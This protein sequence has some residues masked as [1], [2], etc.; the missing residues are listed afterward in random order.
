MRGRLALGVLTGLALLLGFASLGLRSSYPPQSPP[1]QFL[2]TPTSP[3]PPTSTPTSPPT[4]TPIVP[5]ATVAATDAPTNTPV[6]PGP[7]PTGNRGGRPE[8][9]PPLPSTGIQTS[10][11]AQVRGAQG[12]ILGDAPGFSAHHVMSAGND[13]IV[14]VTDGP[15]RAD[16]YWWWK[17]ITRDSRTGW[18]INDQIIPYTGECF[19]MAAGLMTTP[20]VQGTPIAGAAAGSSPAQSTA[21]ASASQLPSTGSGPGALL[22]GGALAVLLLAAGLIRRRRHGTT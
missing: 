15:Q 9:P 18:G 1:A 11:C 22:V 6:P 17:V 13:D 19:A 16:G 2:P 7:Q 10:A 4:N 8:G 20:G 14:F 5:S 21:A 3:A 12:L